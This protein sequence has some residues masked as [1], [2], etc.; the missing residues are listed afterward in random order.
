MS[1]LN[2]I[3]DCW[4]LEMRKG[5]AKL[6]VL[7]FLN[8]KPLTGYSIMA[9]INKKTFGLWKLT[10]GGVYPILKDL[11]A[12]KYIDGEWKS[13]AGRRK[14]TYNI[15]AEGRQLLSTA[16]Q[17][18]QQMSKTIGNLFREFSRDILGTELSSTS[19]N[20]I[21]DSFPFIRNLEEKSIDEQLLILRNIRTR[22]REMGS[23]IDKKLEKLE[24]TK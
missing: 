8:K 3:A 5:Y 1:N 19:M 2:K 16:I 4:V 6:A 18:Q 11:E 20:G 10:A 12:K 17:R 15:T 9:E 23:C 14:K 7:M 24:E 21:I 13:E 22:L